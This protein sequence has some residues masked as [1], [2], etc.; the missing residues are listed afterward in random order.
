MVSTLTRY[1]G[2]LIPDH[3][4]WHGKRVH[5][6][7][8]TT[9]S[10]PD[11]EENQAVYSQQAGQKPGLGFPICRIVGVICLSSGAILNSALSRFKGKGSGE[12]SLLRG[13]LDSFAHGDLVLGDAF[14]GTYFLLAALQEQGPYSKIKCTTLL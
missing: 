3:W 12:Q 6:I 4:L 2:E 1:T 13:L 9:V 7:D 10:M 5:L 8:G 11:T 14:F